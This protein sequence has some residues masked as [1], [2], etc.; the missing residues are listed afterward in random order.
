MTHGL[1]TGFLVA[2]E[3]SGHPDHLAARQKLRQYRTAGDRFALAPQ[4]LAEF[5]HV[6]TD[7]KRFS[8]PLKTDEALTRDELWWNSPEV[9]QL[10]PDGPTIT[11]FLG[12][13]RLHFLGRKC[14]LDTMLAATFRAE[15]ISSV[16]TTTARDFVVLGGFVCVTP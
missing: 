14:I 12:W 13:I 7:L 4:V 5:I 1:D 3:V 2:A 11:I 6:V 10:N 8:Q 9:Y 16:L 15:Q